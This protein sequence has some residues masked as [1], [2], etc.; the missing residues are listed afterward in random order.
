MIIDTHTHIFPP[1]AGPSGHKSTAE[2]MRYVQ[3]NLTAHHQPVRR[4]DDNTVRKDRGLFNG[5]DYTLEG[6]TDVNFRGGGHGTFRWT[7]N[8]VDYYCQY[9]PPSS[10][11]LEATADGL[12][13]QMDYVGIDKALVQAGHLYGRLN[14]HLS[15]AVARYPERLWA[16]ALVD[17]WLIDQPS[18][19]EVLDHALNELNLKGLWYQAGNA[20]VLGRSELSDDPAFYAFWDHV[21]DL[22]IPVMWNMYTFGPRDPNKFL[23]DIQVFNRWRKRY[24]NVPVHFP[25]GLHT[26]HFME[27]GVPAVPDDV[28]TA[29]EETKALVEILIPIFQGANFDYPYVEFQPV[30]RQYYERLGPDHIS[31]GSD[32]PNVERHCTYKQS[33]DYLRSYCDFIPAADMDKILGGSAARL[34]NL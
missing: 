8:G 25:H 33:I 7:I 2:H 10:T 23:G 30:V 15:E 24:P 28:W 18:Q 34:F 14:Q 20:Q 26:S 12:I 9:L 4:V 6:L 17:E 13:A 11:D 16:P 5:D 1:M 29:L 27:T 31:W 19:I 32:M 22:G 3:Q 21:A